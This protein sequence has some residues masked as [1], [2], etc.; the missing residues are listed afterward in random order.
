MPERQGAPP[1]YV[2]H[3][4]PRNRD[5]EGPGPG[6]QA[7]GEPPGS[8]SS[9]ARAG[10]AVGSAPAFVYLRARAAAVS[11]AAGRVSEAW[12]GGAAWAGRRPQT[13]LGPRGPEQAWPA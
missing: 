1:N 10:A 9:V 13:L 11:E 4:A 7:R 5:D 6:G 8:C 3:S 12:Q 2:S